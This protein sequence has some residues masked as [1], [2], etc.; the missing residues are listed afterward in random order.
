MKKLIAVVCVLGLALSITACSSSDV[1]ADG[2][3]TESPGA[4]I[5]DE[6][7]DEPDED[8]FEAEFTEE[9][10]SP[11]PEV[12]DDDDDDGDEYDEVDEVQEDELA[13]ELADDDATE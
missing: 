8:A 6:F 4:D 3:P 12:A 1:G 13:D 11:E 5:D 2:V 10:E 9:Q 7:Q